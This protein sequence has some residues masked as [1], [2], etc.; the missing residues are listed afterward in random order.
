MSKKVGL[1]DFGDELS[2]LISEYGKSVRINLDEAIKD[3]AKE[4]AKELKKAG[5]F[6]G[7]EYRR[8]WTS[9]KQPS[10]RLHVDYVVYNK[11]HYQLTHLLEFG[12]VKQN[13]GRTRAFPHIAPV[14]D[15]VADRVISFLKRKVSE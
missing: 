1:D 7:K 5:T 14:N 15:K 4:S 10:K 11:E 2:K 3:T 9:K 12:H 8:S 13:G 6:E